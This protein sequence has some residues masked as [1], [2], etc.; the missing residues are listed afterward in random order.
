MVLQ[1]DR[2]E[3]WYVDTGT[4][5]KTCRELQVVRYTLYGSEILN[6]TYSQHFDCATVTKRKFPATDVFY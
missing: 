6:H 5:V 2:G 1:A 3:K 4:L